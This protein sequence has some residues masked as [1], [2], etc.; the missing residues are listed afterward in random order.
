MGRT[1]IELLTSGDIDMFDDVAT[2]LT[3]AVADIR[4]PDKRNSHFSKTIK[5]PG[6]KGNNIRFGH[7]FNINS[8]G[9]FNPNIKAPCT[10]YIDDVP[11]LYGFL[12]VLSIDVDDKNDLIYNCSIKGNVSN[13]FQEIGDAELTDLDFSSFDHV[14]NRVNQKATWTNTYS[15]GYCYPLIDYGFDSNLNNYKVEHLMPAIFLRTYIDKIFSSVGYTYSSTFL[16]ST[17][18]NNLIIP[19]NGERFKYSEAQITPRLFEAGKSA[20]QVMPATGAAGAGTNPALYNAVHFDTDVNDPSNAFNTT[21][22]KW[23]VPVTGYYNVISELNIASSGT[24]ASGIATTIGIRKFDSTT[25]VYSLV[26]TSLYGVGTSAQTFSVSGQNLFLRTT[27]VLD[28]IVATVGI[29]YNGAGPAWIVNTSGSRFYNSIS[30]TGLQAGDTVVMNN[31]VPLKIKQKDLLLDI[32]RMFNLYVEV[33]KNDSK[34]LN[35][36]TRDDFYSNGIVKDWTYKLDNSK[37]VEITPMG[38]LDFKTLKYSY[39]EDKDYYNKKSLDNYAITYGNR[40]IEIEN[41]FLKNTNETKVMFSPTPLVSDVGDDRVIPRIWE[42][43]NNNVVSQKAFNI[44]LLYNG[45]TKTTIKPYQYVDSTV[46][47]TTETSYLYAGHLDS[48]TAPTFDLSF[49]FPKELYYDTLIYT[50]ANLYNLYHKKQIDEIA[51]PDSKIVTANFHLTPKDIFELD[52]RNSFYFE[53][54][55]FRLNKIYDYNPIDESVTKCEF[56][57]IKEGRSFTRTNF[58][59]NGG[60]TGGYS[61]VN[62]IGGNKPITVISTPPLPPISTT[63]LGIGNVVSPQLRNSYINGDNNYVHGGNNIN[64]LNSSGNIIYDGLENVTL[65]NTSGTTVTSSNSLIVYGVSITSGTIASL[66]NQW[67]SGSNA[68]SNFK[69]DT[70]NSFVS[71]TITTNRYLVVGKTMTWAFKGLFASSSNPTNIELFLPG[72]N[73]AKNTHTTR[74]VRIT[75]STEENGFMACAAGVNYLSVGNDTGSPMGSTTVEIEFVIT[76]EIQ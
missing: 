75:A 20:R 50:D 27:D 70:I 63:V 52:F 74:G 19:C 9:S 2:P 7:L 5:V 47:T 41:D 10:L 13:I 4:T 72:G 6:T 45:G 31:M 28:V 53:G 54:Q 62:S 30:N 44:R 11:Q 43:D 60:Y 48:V 23:T 68:S 24:T 1:R 67:Q 12:Q 18:F 25:G 26:A 61:N 69:W 51:D 57:K 33:D 32:I 29:A 56:I 14:L 37:P 34:K 58:S 65:I 66:A 71:E 46:S 39:K 64:L 49:D 15:N 42:V 3:F 59:L 36:E 55:Y 38:D 22:W 17:H 40:I 8:V 35:I 21:T 76:L 16:T 73:I